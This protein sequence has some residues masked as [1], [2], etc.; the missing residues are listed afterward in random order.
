[1]CWIYRDIRRFN[2]E[3]RSP[4]VPFGQ[5]PLSNWRYQEIQYISGLVAI[6]TPLDYEVL[7]LPFWLPEAEMRLFYRGARRVLLD[8]FGD[9]RDGRRAR[10]YW[11]LSGQFKVPCFLL[12][13]DAQI[14][15]G[16][17]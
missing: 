15:F 17:P 9:C 3:T 1:M 4:L 10:S 2:D 8:Y 7:L 14:F 11:E 5:A 12:H 13:N 6:D 16:V